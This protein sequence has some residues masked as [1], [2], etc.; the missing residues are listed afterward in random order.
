MLSRTL[1]SPDS[2]AYLQYNTMLHTHI[3]E[4]TISQQCC[5]RFKL[6]S[7]L[8]PEL[9]WYF[10]SLHTAWFQKE[11][12]MVYTARNSVLWSK[13]N[14]AQWGCSTMCKI[15]AGATLRVKCMSLALGLTR[16]GVEH[17]RRSCSNADEDDTVCTEKF[18]FRS[19]NIHRGMKAI[20]EN[21][22]YKVKNVYKMIWN[23][24]NFC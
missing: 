22:F 6:L 4:L 14:L 16:I 10:L 11:G 19:T 5:Q 2:E 8:A 3:W 20:L 24:L 7:F 15:S 1:C 18:T 13:C 17:Q 9:W 23:V 21:N 12:I